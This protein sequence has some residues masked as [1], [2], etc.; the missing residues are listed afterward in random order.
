MKRIRYFHEDDYC[1]REFLPLAS[2]DH[3]ASEI[4]K[5]DEFS[6]AHKAPIGWTKVY[7]R[8]AAPA[9]LRDV[10]LT[11]EE[12]ESAVGSRLPRYDEVLTGYASHREPSPHT[13]AFGSDDGIALFVDLDDQRRVDAAWLDSHFVD[14][15]VAQWM[16]HCLTGLPRADELLFIDWSWSHLQ[17]VVDNDAWTRYFEAHVKA[18]REIDALLTRR[19]ENK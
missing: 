6:N 4:V 7:A 14:S 15:D 12:I 8:G 5:I 2:W 1:Q 16:P 19:K 11:V 17:R 3:C 9:R 13:R 10:G 18:R